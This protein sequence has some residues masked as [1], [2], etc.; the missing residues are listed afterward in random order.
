MLPDRK[1][2]SKE[3][4]KSIENGKLE[5]KYK[6]LFFLREKAVSCKKITVYCKF[7]SYLYIKYIIINKNKVI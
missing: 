4:M 6:R 3:E 1:I 5:G 7:N 2:S